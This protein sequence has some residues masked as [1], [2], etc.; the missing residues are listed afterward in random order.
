[1]IKQVKT[2]F[3]EDLEDKLE[4]IQAMLVEKIPI[5]KIAKYTRLPIEQVENAV[6]E[7]EIQK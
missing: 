7:I 5:V 3:K 2:V 1:M 6:K 4:M